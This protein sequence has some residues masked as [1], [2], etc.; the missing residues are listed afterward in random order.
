MKRIGVIGI[1][2]KWSSETLADAAHAATGER[3]LIDIRDVALD[4]TSNK[5]R[6]KELDLCQFDALIIKKLGATY[7]PHMV[8]RIEV[9]YFLK[10]QGV[11]IFSSPQ[12][13]AQ[14]IDRLRCT[15]T[16]QRGGIP[17]PPTIVTEN[18]EAATQAVKTFE[19]AVLKP[20]WT[21]KA[22][23]MEVLQA[24]TVNTTSFEGFLQLGQ[25]TLYLQK[26]MEIPGRDLGVTF[27]GGKYL[28]SYARVSSGKSWNTTTHSGGHYEP[29]EP[30]DEIIAIAQKAQDLF[31]LDFTCVDVM[32][33]PEGPMVLEVSAFGGFRGLRDA[34]NI[35]VAERYVAHVLQQLG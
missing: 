16:L 34:H 7:S 20:I 1:P 19:K 14:A 26:L 17:I 18:I 10:S 35:D 25:P 13:I 3:H 4:L 24:D 15:L 9:L 5:V 28:A 22:R 31:G 32:E 12:S 6:S 29:S 2:G 30:S 27:L 8:E 21:S 33:T 23:G 11:K